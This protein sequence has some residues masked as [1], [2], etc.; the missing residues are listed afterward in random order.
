MKWDRNCSFQKDRTEIAKI[1]KSSLEREDWGNG[2]DSSPFFRRT[3]WALLLIFSFFFLTACSGTGHPAIMKSKSNKI[4]LTYGLLANN[5]DYTLQMTKRFAKEVKEKSRGR[6]E[7]K[8]LSPKDKDND[9]AL[10]ERFRSGNL[11]MVRLPLP[12]AKKLSAKLSLMEL[13]YLFDSEEEMWNVLDGDK[14]AIFQEDFQSKGMELLV[15]HCLGFRDFYTVEKPLTSAADFD[16]LILGVEEESRMGR[17]L[18]LLFG[19][20][21]ELPQDKIY[22]ALQSGI[23]EGSENTIEEF[24]RQEHNLS[25]KYFL[26][27]DHSPVLDLQ[28]LSSRARENLSEEDLALLKDVSFS[29]ALQER[30]YVKKMRVELRNKLSK[31]GVLFSHFSK[32][33][34]AKIKELLAPLYQEST[35][36][37]F[38][39]KLGKID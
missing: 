4:V 21:R 35:E 23:V 3:F 38:L 18:Q 10:L 11:D 39:R 36:S 6:I 20:T 22:K 14:G 25:A 1:E 26:E 16:G 34:K 17:A 29:M 2:S 9:L 33:E 8:F 12:S 31:R 30:A 15:W 13:P 19:K 32:E 27:D 28:I 5:D 7:I 24:A 37:D